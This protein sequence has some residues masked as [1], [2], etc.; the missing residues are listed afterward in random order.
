VVLVA[1]MKNTRFS[2]QA[3]LDALDARMKQLE[4]D[5]RFNRGQG[6][7]VV[8]KRSFRDVIAFG[9]YDALRDMMETIEGGYL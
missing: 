1:E 3:V 5:H 8:E 9:Q 4:K 7:A 2:K 6:Y